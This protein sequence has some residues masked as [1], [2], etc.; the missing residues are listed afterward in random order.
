VTPLTL[1]EG[2][3]F[4]GAVLFSSTA[5]LRVLNFVAARSGLP[6]PL[7]SAATAEVWVPPTAKLVWGVNVPPLSLRP[8]D[9]GARTCRLFDCGHGVVF[10]IKVLQLVLLYLVRPG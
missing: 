4:G 2:L 3:V 5:T 10:G 7:K 8:P 6:S 1:T 9:G